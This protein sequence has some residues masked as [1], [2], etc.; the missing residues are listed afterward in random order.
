MTTTVQTLGKVGM[1]GR[2]KPL[3]NAAARVLESLCEQATD[4]VIGIGS[5][6]KYNAR[7]PFTAQETRGMIDSFLKPRYDNYDI[8]EIPDFA[9]IPEYSDGMKWKE[10]VKET[11]GDLNFFVSSNPYVRG[12]L[13]GSFPLLHTTDVLKPSEYLKLNATEVRTAMARY[14]EWQTLVPGPVAAYLEER[15][16]VERFRKEFGLATL[17]NLTDTRGDDAAI[18]ALHA[19]EA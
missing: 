14:D 1:I 8:C 12:L 3:H 9:H 4:V 10:H 7:C 16:L 15:G 19:R 5:A 18:E 13:K 17:A 11:F 6:N 2:F